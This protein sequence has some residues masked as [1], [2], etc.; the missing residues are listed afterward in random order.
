MGVDDNDDRMLDLMIGI[1]QTHVS[2]VYSPLR[3]TALASKYNLEP[4]FAM[5]IATFDPMGKTLGL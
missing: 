2:E 3:V 5:D 4:G 1:V